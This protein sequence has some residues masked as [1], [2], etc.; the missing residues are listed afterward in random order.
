[1]KA[2]LGLVIAAAIVTTMTAGIA[3]V[4]LS[5]DPRAFGVIVTIAGIVAGVLAIRQESAPGARHTAPVQ[6]P[7]RK[8]DN[9]PKVA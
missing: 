9:L 6:P 5:G 3:A 4:W 7:S 1:M 2:P 8:T